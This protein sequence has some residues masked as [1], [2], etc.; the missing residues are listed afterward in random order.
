MFLRGKPWLV[1]Q[2]ITNVGDSIIRVTVKEKN[3]DYSKY[4]GV[5]LDESEII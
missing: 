4:L 1:K 2:T 3:A 5:I